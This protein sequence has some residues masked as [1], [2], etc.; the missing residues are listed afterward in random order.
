[1]SGNAPINLGGGVV[2]TGGDG[3]RSTYSGAIS[4]SG[5]L[6]QTGGILILAATARRLEVLA[7]V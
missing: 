2:T 4:G 3:T 5:G 6:V 7:G 1:V